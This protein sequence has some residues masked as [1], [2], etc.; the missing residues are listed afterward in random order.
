[1]LLMPIRSPEPFGMVMVGARLRN[2]SHR[3]SKGSAGEIV[4][5]GDPGFLAAIRSS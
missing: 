3:L 4:V 1:V 5:H 2:A